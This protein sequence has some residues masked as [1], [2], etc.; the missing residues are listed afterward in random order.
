M[1]LYQKLVRNVFYPLA[2]W[3]SGDAGQLRWLREFERT[4]Y[5]PPDRLRALQLRRLRALLLHAYD[6]CPFYRDRFDGR[7]LRPEDVRTL[8]DL[9]LLPPLEKGDLQRRGAD[10]VARGWP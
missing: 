9:A 4:Q 10:M 3:R 2:L 8:D 5:L 6:R 1:R 7:G